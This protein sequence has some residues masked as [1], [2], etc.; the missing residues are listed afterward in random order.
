MARVGSLI[1]VLASL[2]AADDRTCPFCEHA[3]EPAAREAWVERFRCGGCEADVNVYSD[4]SMN[5]TAFV[6]G[7]RRVLVQASPKLEPPPV[8]RERRARQ[9]LNREYVGLTAHP[10]G[11]MNH[12]VRRPGH[13]VERPNHPVQ[14]PG[15]AVG[16]M[17]APV[18]RPGQPVERPGHP[19]RR[20][21]PPV[22]RPGHPV[23]RMNHPVE[24]PGIAV[25]RPGHPVL[26]PGAPLG[27]IRSVGGG[28]RPGSNNWPRYKDRKYS[29]PR[30]YKSKPRRYAP[31]R[32]YGN[33][34]VSKGATRRTRG[35]RRY[36]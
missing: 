2:A 8:G 35:V 15:H 23:G 17:N 33:K 1:L 9:L 28:R 7:E 36:R 14:S 10:I 16:R 34:K 18:E 24:R 11:R 4:R 21:N 32:T 25:V 3:L 12:P 26:R 5:A 29:A 19:V 6:N 27:R 20:M 22:E 31:P 30:T 13:P